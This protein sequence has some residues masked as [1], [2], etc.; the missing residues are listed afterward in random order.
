[1][2]N[3]ARVETTTIESFGFE[4]S[5]LQLIKDTIAKGTTNE[6]LQLFL[7]TC[8]RTGLDPLARQIYCIKRWDSNL[9][10]E[11][12]TPQTSIDGYRL[13]ADRTGNYAPGRAPTYEEGEQGIIAATAYVMKYVR[14]TWHEVSATAYWDEYAQFKKNGNPTHMWA[15]KPRVMLGKCAESLALRRAFPAE[16]SGLY[17]QDEMPEAEATPQ[18]MIAMVQPVALPDPEVF[19]R[20]LWKGLA[21][22][23]T[24]AKALGLSVQDVAELQ[25]DEG[26]PDEVIITIGKELRRDIEAAKV[27]GDSNGN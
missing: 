7:Y 13:I 15:T 23:V 11:V 19:R 12:A 6:E 27:R 16:L 9:G 24:E 3:L 18:P 4:P 22:L 14:G 8:Q 26:T 2:T 5:K 1:M 10:R 17:T 25:M 20:R 21:A